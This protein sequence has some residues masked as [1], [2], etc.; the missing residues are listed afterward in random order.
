MN[1]NLS[2]E[3]STLKETHTNI[4][5]KSDDEIDHG[6]IPDKMVCEAFIISL[7]YRIK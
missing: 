3:R 7:L 2:L 4:K 5:I 6:I 1:M